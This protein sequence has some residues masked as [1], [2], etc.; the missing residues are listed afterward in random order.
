MQVGDKNA[1]G[2]RITAL[3][4]RMVDLTCETCHSAGAA[5]ATEFPSTRCGSN[6]CG[7]TQGR[8]E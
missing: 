1:F 2:M 4:G 7:A 8:T 5:P 3:K 6:R